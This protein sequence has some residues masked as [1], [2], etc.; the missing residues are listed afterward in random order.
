MRFQHLL[1]STALALAV[2]ATA[3]PIID[4][5]PILSEHDDLT[6]QQIDL[7]KE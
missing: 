6:T 5:K 1:L 3:S 4:Q 2:T 7:I